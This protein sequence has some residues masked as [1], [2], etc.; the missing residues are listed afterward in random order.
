MVSYAA[1]LCHDGSPSAPCYGIQRERSKSH[2]A[3]L[4]SLN[5]YFSEPLIH[6][7]TF[8]DQ[9][10]AIVTRAEPHCYRRPVTGVVRLN[11]L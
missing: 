9:I 6:L 1:R 2:H 5:L 11:H 3:R 8:M 4:I 7:T 10:M